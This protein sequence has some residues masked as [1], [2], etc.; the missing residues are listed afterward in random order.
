MLHA[1]VVGWSGASTN[2]R[3][4]RAACAT[5]GLAC[6]K[7]QEEEDDEVSELRILQR[8]PRA[9][10]ARPLAYGGLLRRSVFASK[11]QAVVHPY[12]D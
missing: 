6:R 1:A 10:V 3:R 5:I 7:H 4:M 2:G 12:R 11:E 9:G 8:F